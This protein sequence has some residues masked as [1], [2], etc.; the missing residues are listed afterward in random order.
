[1][2]HLSLLLTIVI[3]LIG[4]ASLAIAQR[5]NLSRVFGRSTKSE[6][7]YLTEDDLNK[8]TRIIYT[9]NPGSLPPEYHYNCI[10]TVEPT[11]VRLK[12]NKGYG[13]KKLYDETFP[14]SE[15][16][17]HKMKTQLAER[18]IGNKHDFEPLCGGKGGCLE[19][20]AQT[21]LLFRGIESEGLVYQ[22]RL[23]N[24]FTSLL[25]EGQPREILQDPG[26]LLSQDT[27]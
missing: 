25:P 23:R 4:L 19:L 2:K 12:V 3:S 27:E 13:E 14:V 26:I 8:A 17:W 18:K 24:A 1:M 20:Y 21:L 6:I 11:E 7:T 5:R 22:G 9:T 10:L 15:A 16:Q